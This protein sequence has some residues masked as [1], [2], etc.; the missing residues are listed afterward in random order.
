MPWFSI[1]LTQFIGA[2]LYW[3]DKNWFYAWMAV[4]KQQFG[5][6][7]TTM[8]NWWAPV[9][10][11]VSGDESVRGQ[12]TKTEDGRLECHFPERLILIA[13]HQVRG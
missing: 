1:A 11:V 12:L 2:P 10:M 13:N 6:L 7:V 4:T 8:T 3:Y 5:V 9:K